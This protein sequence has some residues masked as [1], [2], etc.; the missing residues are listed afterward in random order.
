DTPGFSLFD[1][2]EKPEDPAL[3]CDWYPEFAQYMENC[4]FQPCFHDTEPG[5]AVTEAVAEG[6]L[7]GERVNRYRELY[8]ISKER[9]KNRY[10]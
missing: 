5:C 6:K 4:R 9:W 7:S 1:E 10:D 3:L 2:I 8:R